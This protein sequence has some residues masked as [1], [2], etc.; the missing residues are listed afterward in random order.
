MYF[1]FVAGADFTPGRY[2]ATFSARATKA[3]TGIPIM[4]DNIA[5]GTEQFNLRLYIDGAGYG[6]GLQNGNVKNATAFIMQPNITGN[7]IS[8]QDFKN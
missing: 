7:F 1:Y 2:N 3:T 5:E 4:V 8:R 6:L